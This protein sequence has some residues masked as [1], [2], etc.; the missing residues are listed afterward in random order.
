MGT[1]RSNKK[2][3]KK[4]R[5]PP[6]ESPFVTPLPPPPGSFVDNSQGFFPGVSGSSNW[7][8]P[9]NPIRSTSKTLLTKF[10]LSEISTPTLKRELSRMEQVRE[11]QEIL[12]PGVE[13]DRTYD[14]SDAG[15]AATPAE[16]KGGVLEYIDWL[17]IELSTR[18]TRRSSSRAEARTAVST[19]SGSV[20]TSQD[21]E[22]L[23][24]PLKRKRGRQ[25]DP[26]VAKRRAIIRKFAT[27]SAVKLCREFDDAQLPLPRTE[28]WDRDHTW[29]QAYSSNGRGRIDK[30]ISTDKRHLC[31]PS[32]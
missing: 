21:P 10:P 17:K 14:R 29:E 28:S 31:K 25:I 32:G 22:Q 30:M 11:E 23:D 8:R 9:E 27:Y 24:R 3:Q 2:S 5:R 15:R 6:R 16:A 19:A 4:L 26:D 7:H 13:A 20:P 12:F 18:R 1:G